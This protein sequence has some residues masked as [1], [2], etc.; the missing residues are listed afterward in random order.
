[1]GDH[2]APLIAG[3]NPWW[4]TDDREHDNHD[5]FLTFTIRLR[6]EPPT[7]LGFL[8]VSQTGGKFYVTLP[9]TADLAPRASN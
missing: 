7:A 4:I 3:L 9:P 5:L 6:K 8:R 2:F 1:L